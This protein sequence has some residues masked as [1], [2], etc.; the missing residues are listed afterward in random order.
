MA[1][2][3]FTDLGENFDHKEESSNVVADA[4]EEDSSLF[5]LKLMF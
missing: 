1:E 5:V 4:P 3:G 2:N